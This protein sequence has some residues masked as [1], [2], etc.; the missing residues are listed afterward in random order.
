M[1]E[2]VVHQTPDEE[3]R[4]LGKRAM[5]VDCLKATGVD[6]YGDIQQR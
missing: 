2:T 1:E 6:V 5:L 3:K 4:G